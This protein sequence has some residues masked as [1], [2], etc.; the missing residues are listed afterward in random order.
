MDSSIISGLIGGLAAVII[1]TYISKLARSSE[2]RGQLKF[3]A[4]MVVLAWSCIALSFFAFIMFFVDNDVWL[5]R[6]ELY[7][8]IA[9]F[10][11]FGV[12]GIYCF[13]EYFKV[14]GT[15]DDSEIY[16]ST[17][18]TGVKREKWENLKKV[19]FNSIANWY[20]LTFS[21]GAKIRLSNMLN[22]HGEVINLL[23]EKGHNF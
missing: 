18:W 1:C 8:V 7:S 9:L 3:G 6:S 4:F 14:E 20:V 12:A 23:H 11:G 13:G 22:G 5:K 16:F 15:F 2:S 19:K 17:P 10:F 21:S